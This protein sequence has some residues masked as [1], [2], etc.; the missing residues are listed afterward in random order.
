MVVE[1]LKYLPAKIIGTSTLNVMK[2]VYLLFYVHELHI[3]Q[4][5]SVNI[6]HPW[7]LQDQDQKLAGKMCSLMFLH[8]C[9]RLNYKTFTNYAGTNPG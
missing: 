1:P 3:E 2:N 5:E 8:P 4:N 6:V 9:I 7:L